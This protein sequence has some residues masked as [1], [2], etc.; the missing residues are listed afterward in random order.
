MPE[1]PFPSRPDRELDESLLDMIVNGQ[2][3]PPDSPQ[4]MHAL[5]AALADLAGPAEPGK[6]AGEAA[7]RFAF[8]HRRASPAGVLP[9]AR[10]AR[11]RQSRFSR[12][13]SARLAAV[14]VAAA[15]G[16]GGTAAVYV[17]MLPG[18][19]QDFAHVIGARP[20]RAGPLKAHPGRSGMGQP[21]HRKPGRQKVPAAPVPTT[22]GQGKGHRK[23]TAP[24]GAATATCPHGTKANFR[25]HYSA[26]GSGGWSGTQSAACPGSLAIGPQA[27][28]GDLK[29]SPGTRLEVGYDF[30]VPG[31]HASFSLTVST[32]RVVFAVACLSGATPSAR[33]FTI[34]MPARTYRVTSDQW[35]PSGDQSS[36]L[37]DQGSIAVPD[38]CGGG[39]LRLDQGG[40]FTASV[41]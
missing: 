24:G 40:T 35:Y 20:H 8:T 30:T 1:F 2:S 41:G 21:G 6:L 26:G 36:L 7:A 28:E 9:A 31:N 37:A 32:P 23:G 11:R 27:M 39:Q 38:L 17:G 4:E 18:P 19:V 3:L 16:L 29:V 33:T 15:L 25:W 13:L 22:L 10:P 12:V 14:L 34:P 5:A